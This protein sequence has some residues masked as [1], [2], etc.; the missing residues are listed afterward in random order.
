MEWQI[1]GIGASVTP[2][3]LEAAFVNSLLD[4]LVE[5]FEAIPNIYHFIDL[6]VTADGDQYVRTWD[7]SPFPIHQG[8]VSGLPNENIYQSNVPWSRDQYLNI[9][10]I[11]FWAFAKYGLDPYS[12][13]SLQGYYDELFV[14]NVAHEIT[15]YV[16]RIF[17]TVTQITSS[18]QLVGDV[19]SILSQAGEPISQF[20]YADG[21]EVS[22]SQMNSILPGRPLDPFQ[23]TRSH[24]P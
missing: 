5:F 20:G 4:L 15:G 23:Q 24:S 10:I 1:S 17:E 19:A 8:F 6:F 22:D 16:N 13:P 14:R 7:H 11:A 12:A 9:N 18:G 21:S 3:D 2:D